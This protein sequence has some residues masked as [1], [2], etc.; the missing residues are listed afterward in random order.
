MCSPEHKSPNSHAVRFDDTVWSVSK[1]CL[2][3]QLIS[4]IAAPRM[5]EVEAL[6][7][8]FS[9]AVSPGRLF[10][11]SGPERVRQSVTAL[12]LWRHFCTGY[13]DFLCPVAARPDRQTT[14]A[15]PP[16]PWKPKHNT[17]VTDTWLMDQG[18]RG[19]RGRKGTTF[20]AHTRWLTHRW[21]IFIQTC[22]VVVGF[23]GGFFGF[24]WTSM[25]PSRQIGLKTP[26]LWFD[27]ARCISLN[28]AKGQTVPRARPAL[29]LTRSLRMNLSHVPI[30]PGD[31]RQTGK[32]QQDELTLDGQRGVRVCVCVRACV[33]SKLSVYMRLCDALS[34]E[35]LVICKSALPWA[36]GVKVGRQEEKREGREAGGRRTDGQGDGVWMT[37]MS[38]K[39]RRGRRVWEWFILHN[40]LFSIPGKQDDALTCA[41]TRARYTHTRMR[42]FAG[43]RLEWIKRSAWFYSVLFSS[44]T[45]PMTTNKKKSKRYLTYSSVP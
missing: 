44:S 24:T 39:E 45:N 11:S 22:V 14:C 29:C 2:Q 4:F 23:F 32:T 41:H 18:K 40:W 38:V 12:P 5:H 28:P 15:N 42:V 35:R 25:N 9:R 26:T 8:F 10:S 37:G 31:D 36:G 33:W 16:S 1:H 17:P 27:S 43:D 21:Q 30:L 34:I 20:S 19:Q 13:T 3:W 7:Y 6:H